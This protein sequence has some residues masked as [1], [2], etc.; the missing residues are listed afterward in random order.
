SR[1]AANR[2]PRL[3][4]RAF[5][6][7]AGGAVALTTFGGLLAACGGSSS[8]TTTNSS[9]SSSATTSSG[10]GS[11]STAA[12][13]STMASPGSSTAAA[14]ASPATSS[15]G[16]PKE[17]KG[18]AIYASAVDIPNIDPAVGHDGATA[19]TEKHL[20]D[21]LYRHMHNPPQLV[22]WLATGNEASP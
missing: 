11:T 8:T 17:G 20:Y 16:G 15:G 2:F 18:T 3:T 7:G 22:P 6:R 1:P 19:T 5:L 13:T 21:P 14:V 12:A 9:A 4:R 10:S